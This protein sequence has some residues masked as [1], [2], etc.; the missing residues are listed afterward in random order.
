M[1]GQSLKQKWRDGRTSPGMWLRLTD[2]LVAEMIGE[3][4]FDWVII[5][6]EHAAYDMQPLQNL[7]VALHG[8][9]TIPIVR[10]HTNDPT[11][12][13]RVLDIGA[14]GVLVPQLTSAA[15][16][17]AAIAACR[18]PPTGIRGAGPR[19]ASRFG[20]VPNYFATANDQ[21]IVLVMLEMVGAVNELDA[22]LKLPGVDGLVIGPTDL[23]MGMGLQ[24][25]F[26]H[27]AV[28]QAV[29]AVCVKARAAGIPFGTGMPADDQTVWV[30]RGATLIPLGDDE[31]FIHRGA[32]QA[33]NS[34]KQNLAGPSAGQG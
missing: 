11:H 20:H 6:A 23:A 15:E 33:L 10:V 16:V 25:N 28:Q 31:Y 17:E 1:D 22:I 27:P 5:D 13:K 26:G 21:V 9:G 7:L 2:P 32:M 34:F 29:E 12:I 18:Y 19:R 4:G 30:K 14:G 24:G 8:S 3:L